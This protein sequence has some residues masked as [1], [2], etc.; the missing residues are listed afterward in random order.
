[1]GKQ[2]FDLYGEERVAAIRADVAEAI[3]A[4]LFG[5][6]SWDEVPAA[7]SRAFPGSFGAFWNINFGESRV[8]MFSSHNVD[9]DFV[10]SYV[11]H[12]A[13]INP[14]SAYWAS[15]TSGAAVLSENVLPARMIADTEFYNDWL[16]PQKDVDAG[17]GMKLVGD[18]GENIQFLTNFP[19]SMSETYGRATVA[20]L[21]GVRGNLQRAVSL[22]RL[23][24][25]DAEG[26]MVRAAL[27]ERVRG[28]AFVVEGNRQLREANQ[29]AVE[30]FASGRSVT[31]RNGRCAMIDKTADARF[32]FAI[33]RLSRG[34][35]IDGSHI[36]FRT[37]TGAWRVTMAALPAAPVWRGVLSLLPPKRLVLVLVTDVGRPTAAT[38]LSVLS[39]MFGL[40]PAEVTFCSRLMLG[41]SVSDA[42]DRLGISLETARTRLKTIFQKT[43]TSR[44]GQLML[45]LSRLL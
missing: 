41:E 38:G 43:D 34:I 21:A 7:L 8:D 39:A 24:R 26:A 22:A 25:A 20:I 42:A 45:L 3:D 32:G 19:L 6:A 40:T 35:P 5:N 9:P 44:Q 23:M 37:S 14:W 18:R 30:L 31:A 11:D 17:A 15:A 10:R 28:A 29:M 36:S 16:H 33:D 2:A 12:F 13:Y 4:A 1:M 27:V